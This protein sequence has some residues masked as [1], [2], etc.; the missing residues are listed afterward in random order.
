MRPG[1]RAVATAALP[2]K[3]LRVSR[4]DDEAASVAV[5]A[6]AAPT[7]AGVT[8]WVFQGEYI[9]GTNSQSR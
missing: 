8:L 2:P 1:T 6:A 3:A 7:A 5:V 9:A 4:S